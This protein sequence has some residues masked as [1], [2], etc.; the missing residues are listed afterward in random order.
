MRRR[1]PTLDGGG[2]GGR[3]I[4]GE[5]EGEIGLSAGESSEGEIG[6]G[7]SDVGRIRDLYMKSRETLVAEGDV[8]CDASVDMAEKNAVNH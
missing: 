2:T 1:L 3:L 4:D 6:W 5:G 7:A 8:P